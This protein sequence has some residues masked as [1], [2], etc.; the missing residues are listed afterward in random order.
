MFLKQKSAEIYIK[1]PREDW[2]PI[3]GDQTGFG[4][5]PNFGSRFFVGDARIEL[6]EIDQ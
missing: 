2:H 4:Y 5:H 1:K 6:N 3:N